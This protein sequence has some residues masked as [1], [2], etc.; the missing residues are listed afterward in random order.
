MVCRGFLAAGRL[1]AV[2]YGSW[3][4]ARYAVCAAAGNVDSGAVFHGFGTTAEARACWVA[5]VGVFPWP[6]AAPASS[7]RR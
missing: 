1:R 7:E 3:G 6:L 2:I 5:A 4:E